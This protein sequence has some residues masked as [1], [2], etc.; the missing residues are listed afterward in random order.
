MVRFAA[1]ARTRIPNFRGIKY[2]HLDVLDF[3][4]CVREH[5]DAM[6]LYWG[7]DEALITGLALGANGAVGSTY[8]FATPI[9]HRL[10]AAHAA[11]D[12]A[13]ARTL[14]SQAAALVDLLAS[15][16]YMA[17]AKATMKYLGVDVGTVRCPMPK[18]A[19]VSDAKLIADLD[20]FGLKDL[21]S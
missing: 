14:Q 10:I 21:R 16:N 2:T 12:V 6:Q 17:A 15:H 1:A 8:N 3:Q 4:A 19:G 9:Y 11:G 5:G 7:C 18:L 13:T 20:Q